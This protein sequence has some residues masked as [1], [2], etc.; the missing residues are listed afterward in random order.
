MAL[1][2][3]NRQETVD[4]VKELN[5]TDEQVQQFEFSDANEA[6]AN[7]EKM[8]QTFEINK[9]KFPDNNFQA[10]KNVFKNICG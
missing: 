6:L 8:M 4:E 3:F 1:E 2:S 7:H 5:L 9:T 10:V